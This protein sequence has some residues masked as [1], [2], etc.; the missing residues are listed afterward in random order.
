M[1]TLL[2]LLTFT[3]IHI[4][5]ARQIEIMLKKPLQRSV[6]GL[7]LVE[8]VFWHILIGT[9]GVTISP[10]HLS[11]P[12]GSQ[13]DRDIWESP[14]VMF[15]QMNGKV[16][17]IEESVVADLSQDMRICYGYAIGIQTGNMKESVAVKRLAH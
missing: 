17:Q 9:D 10:E 5:A 15:P 16:I 11:G 14:V 6:C 13:L 4:G 1:L 2:T 8:L 12:V 7:H 3:G